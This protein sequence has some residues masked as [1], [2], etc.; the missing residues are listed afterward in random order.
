MNVE[1]ILEWMIKNKLSA[2]SIYRLYHH[3]TNSQE[4][5]A[6]QPAFKNHKKKKTSLRFC[7]KQIL[8]YLQ[9]KF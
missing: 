1:I 5:I 2:N 7:Y 6:A 8:V 3:N 9:N 4:W